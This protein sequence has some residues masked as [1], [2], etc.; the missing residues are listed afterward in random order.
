MPLCPPKPKVLLM[1]ADEKSKFVYHL[2]KKGIDLVPVLVEIGLW[3]SLYNP[4]GLDQPLIEQLQRDKAGTI[5]R[6]QE[7]L[8]AKLSEVQHAS[9]EKE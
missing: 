7:R 2:T 4:P 6:I 1:A 8:M 3:G 5:S 9:N